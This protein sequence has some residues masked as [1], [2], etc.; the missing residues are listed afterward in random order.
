M[1]SPL[2]ETPHPWKT[3]ENYALAGGIFTGLVCV[4]CSYQH[5]GVT[6][7]TNTQLTYA[8]LVIGYF[9]SGGTDTSCNQFYNLRYY[10][11]LFEVLA[12][13]F[14]RIF[15]SDVFVG[16][17]LF[18]GLVSVAAIPAVMQAARQ[19]GCRWIGMACAGLALF[20][21]P[22][23][24]GHTCNNSKDLPF[25]V[26]FAW[27]IV[28]MMSLW[29]DPDLPWR[30]VILAAGAVGLT[31]A[32]RAGGILL[33]GFAGLGLALHIW[34]HH[35]RWTQVDYWPRGLLKGAV[36]IAISWL[37]MIACWPWAHENPIL[38]P[39]AAIQ[40]AGSFSQEKTVLLAGSEL[41]SDA[42]PRSYLLRYLWLSTPTVPLLLALIGLGIMI[43]ELRKLRSSHA[44]W[45][46]WV[47]FPLA[48]FAILRPHVY[49]GLRHFLFLL[50]AL[51]VG[52]AV[53]AERLIDKRRWLAPLLAVLALATFAESA[54]WHPYQTSYF[55]PLVGGELHELYDVDYW[56]SSYR[57]AALWIAEQSGDRPVR[58]LLAANKH[59]QVCFTNFATPNME[60]FTIF[61]GHQTGPVPPGIDYYVGMARYGFADFFS[62]SPIVYRIGRSRA[63]L[64]VIRQAAGPLKAA[65]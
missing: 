17:H 11:G 52:A 35:D 22:R 41:T 13:R 60:L 16:R 15:S 24:L 49:D 47:A 30:H 44:L 53:G 33:Y 14:G 36:F 28:L 5:F 58:I 46:L 1:D 55:Q 3:P 32:C 26:G 56:A 64:A 37:L 18:T 62:D 54:R 61:S 12:T 8:D 50:P 29:R 21:L 20:L 38:H 65:E 19:L 57:E 6:W 23:W 4:L 27:S 48:Y 10:G 42:L 2:P 63:R 45:L 59:S 25:A 7:D 34:A 9:A 39:I 31:M 40:E 51:A 43:C